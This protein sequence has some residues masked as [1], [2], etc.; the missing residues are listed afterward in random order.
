MSYLKFKILAAIVCL[1][2]VGTY[3]SVGRGGPPQSQTYDDVE[4]APPRIA[5]YATLDSALEEAKRSQRPILFT[6][7]APNCT[8]VSGIW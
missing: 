8:G 5:W 6:S 4:A 7:A 1:V 3:A 2:A